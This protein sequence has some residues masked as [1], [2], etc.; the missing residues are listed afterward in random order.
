MTK[1]L[2][3]VF[4]QTQQG[5]PP[6]WFMRQA[7]RYLPEYREI[8]Q[9]AGNFLDLCYTSELAEAVTLQPIQRYGFDGAILF[10]DILVIPDALGLEVWFEDGEGPRL[11]PVENKDMIK[12]LTKNLDH[13]DNQLQPVYETLRRLTKSLPNETTLIGFSGSPWTLACY[14]LCGG[15]D[16]G[17]IKARRIAYHNPLLLDELID[18]LVEAISHY[19][20][21]QVQNGAELLQLFDSWSGLLDSNGFKQFVIQPTKRIIDSV[22]AA[23]V[24]VPIIG[25][26][27]G[28]GTLYKDYFMQTKINGISI[29]SSVS[30]QYASEHLLPLGVVQGNLEPLRLQGE[31]SLWQAEVDLILK[32]FYGKPFIFNL[33][34][35]IDKQTNPQAVQDIITYIRSK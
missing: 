30:L 13:I 28:C 25:F 7:G 5:N 17:F 27:R 31:K 32:Y 14:M 8:R 26:P 4:N 11:N 2:L 35:G 19:L 20:I 9:K 23:G 1:K 21:K 6:I 16:P 24:T 15:S 33:G 10:S 12:T 22:R 3:S 18:L 29:D 34:H